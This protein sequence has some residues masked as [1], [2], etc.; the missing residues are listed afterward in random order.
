MNRSVRVLVAL[1]AIRVAYGAWRARRRR[2]DERTDVVDRFDVLTTDVD[3]E[4][5]ERVVTNWSHGY[6]PGLQTDEGRS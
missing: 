3:D 6:V 2:V 5:L 1:V 4:D